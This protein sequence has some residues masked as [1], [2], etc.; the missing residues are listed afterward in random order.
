MKPEHPDNPIGRFV[1]SKLFQNGIL[2]LILLA[3]ALVGIETYPA[4]EAKYGTILHLLD[5]IVLWL[6]V[7]EAV[8]K[9]AQHGKN[10]HRYFKDPWN[11]FDFTIV[12]VCFLP[13]NAQYAAVLRLARILRALRLVSVVPLRSQTRQRAVTPAGCPTGGT[14]PLVGPPAGH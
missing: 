10:W 13:V 7:I 4:M 5:K 12:V 8:L 1:A 11:I 9:M 14:C 6:F 2:L 3:A